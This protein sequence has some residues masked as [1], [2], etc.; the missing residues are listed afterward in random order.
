VKSCNTL[1]PVII[2]CGYLGRYLAKLL[3]NQQQSP[4]CV[5]QSQSSY[6]QLINQQLDCTIYDLDH[7]NNASVTFALAGSQIYYLAPPSNID[8]KDH[9]IDNFLELC[10]ANPP[11]KI[12][13]ISTS[14]VYGDCQ[15]D[16]ATEETPVAPISI[17]AKRRVYA[18]KALRNY[19]RQHGSNYIILR[20]GGIYG[21]KRLPIER[22]KDITVICPEQA[23]HSNRIHV[24]DLASACYSAM[25]NNIQNEVINVAD[26]HSTSMTDYYYKIAD[27]AGLP[28]P[29]C[30][31]MSQAEEKL[32]TGMLSFI[33]E[34]RRLS[35]AKMNNL[36]K[37]E[38]QFPTLEL[39]LEDCFK[40]SYL[41]DL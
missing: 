15:G 31:P 14:G 20:V 18:E 32:S 28:R 9:R 38:I 4:N 40:K 26:G 7:L 36:L 35:T 8:D 5:V 13:Y 34:S 10:A 6:D 24:A 39:G 19:C 33:N 16:W 25:T 27:F 23:P 37:I 41:K 11:S 3:L 12:V 2:G 22:L 30:V 1:Q 21:P 17:R 29:T